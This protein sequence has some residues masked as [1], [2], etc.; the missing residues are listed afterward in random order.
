MIGRRRQGVG[1]RRQWVGK[2]VHATVGQPVGKRRTG[3]PCAWPAWVGTAAHGTS[4]A[5]SGEYYRRFRFFSSQVRQAPPRDE[6]RN[7]P[8]VGVDCWAIGKGVGR[9]AGGAS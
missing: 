6:D 1:R 2:P 8:P 7:S 5:V 3:T 4:D 9:H